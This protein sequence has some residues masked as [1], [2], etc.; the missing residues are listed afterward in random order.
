M[1]GGTD[2]IGTMSD[3]NRHLLFTQGHL[4]SSD[5]TQRNTFRCAPL[6]LIFK[7]QLRFELTHQ[8]ESRVSEGVILVDHRQQSQGAGIEIRAAHQ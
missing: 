2:P 6:R 7:G 3:P 1:V 8:D 5:A 4:W